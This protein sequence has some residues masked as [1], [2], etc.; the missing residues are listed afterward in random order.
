M[1]ILSGAA[2][3]PL[4]FFLGFGGW[5]EEQDVLGESQAP[6]LTR[7]AGKRPLSLGGESN[8]GSVRGP[9]HLDVPHPQIHMSKPP[10]PQDV[11]NLAA[12]QGA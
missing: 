3:L 4:V 9:P 5:L 11:T 7:G 1:F 8:G 6:L 10:V 2:R 12:L